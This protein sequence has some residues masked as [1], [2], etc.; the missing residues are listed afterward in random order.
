M[1]LASVVLVVVGLV[2][3][4]VTLYIRLRQ[5]LQICSSR[6]LYVSHEN[7]LLHGFLPISVAALSIQKEKTVKMKS[8]FI[9]IILRARSRI[10][11]LLYTFKLAVSAMFDI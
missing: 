7:L 1:L 11:Q 9:R 6:K 3:C 5:I 10:Q 4:C 2:A 8:F